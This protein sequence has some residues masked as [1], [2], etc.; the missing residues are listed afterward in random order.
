VATTGPPQLDILPSNESDWQGPPTVV[1]RR[2]PSILR[3]LLAVIVVGGL[4]GVVQVSVGFDQVARWATSATS[5]VRLP[6]SSSPES[7][8][9]A[10]YAATGGTFTA[11][12]ATWQVPAFAADSP[13]GADAIWVGVGGVH[14]N[15]LIQAGTQETVSG[16]G[17]TSYQAWVETLPQASRPVPL[18]INAGDSVSVSL[19][20][21][22]DG[23]WLIAFV[24]NTSGKSYQLTTQY[25]SSHSS[26]EWVVEAPTARRGRLLPLDTFGSVSF[27]QASTVKDGKTVSVAEAGG[28]PITMIAGRGR[29]LARPSALDGDGAS[30]NVL[31]SV[32]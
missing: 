13:A 5:H 28:Q 20:E 4:L 16:H 27:T 25:G 22:T 18:V 10:G 3:A 14:G 6:G 21:Q 19:Q 23:S 24:N 7:S 26:A 1:P 11:V 17:S 8:N 30:F 12:S 9:W 31:Q 2:G 29:P 15:D 32:L